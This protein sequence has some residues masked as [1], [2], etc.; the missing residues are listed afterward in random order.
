MLNG[1][2]LADLVL[3]ALEQDR[4]SGLS[5]MLKILAKSFSA[6]GSILF[7]LAP[8][9]LSGEESPEGNLYVLAEWFEQSRIIAGFH[10]LSLKRSVSGR[11]VSEG[12]SQWIDDTKTDKRV[13]DRRD[14]IIATGVKS[15]ASLPV[16]FEGGKQGALALYRKRCI[17]FSESPHSFLLY[18]RQFARQRSELE[19]KIKRSPA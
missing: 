19:R 16:T 18:I 9:S 2:Q 7:E 10:D 17:P 5:E 3:V 11:A 1:N 6:A 15:L 12:E 4:L 13:G 8:E 14:F